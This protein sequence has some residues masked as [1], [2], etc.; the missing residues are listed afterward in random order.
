MRSKLFSIVLIVLS[1]FIVEV[2]DAS[3]PFIRSNVVDSY[4]AHCNSGVPQE[5]S[6]SIG[7]N[8]SVVVNRPNEA[9]SI[10]TFQVLSKVHSHLKTM[11]YSVFQDL[12]PYFI[13]I[14]IINYFYIALQG[15]SSVAHK[16]FFTPPELS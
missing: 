6:D 9:K 15:E 7:Y 11:H 2:A 8:Q 16:V 4:D 5:A 12:G 14:I 1:S 10:C 3:T 13:I